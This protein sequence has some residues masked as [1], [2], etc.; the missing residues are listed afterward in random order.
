MLLVLSSV[1][2]VKNFSRMRDEKNRDGVDR[3]YLVWKP[4]VMLNIQK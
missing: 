2:E 1:S 4:E 3:Y